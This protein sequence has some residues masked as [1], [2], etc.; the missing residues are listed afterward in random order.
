MRQHQRSSPGGEDQQLRPD[1]GMFH[2]GSEHAGGHRHGD[3]RR[4][5]RNP[6]HGRQQPGQDKGR[7]M[8]AE[9]QANRGLGRA[10]LAQ[11]AAQPTRR[12]EDHHGIGDGLKRLRGELPQQFAAM[13]A[14]VLNTR[15]EK[16]SATRTAM[17][18]AIS[19]LPTK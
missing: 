14:A 10:R 3:G 13:V 4:A 1:P 12:R 17:S 5:H 2:Q 7:H 6:H 9:R 15:P 19:G 8:R 16:T 18:R 11:H